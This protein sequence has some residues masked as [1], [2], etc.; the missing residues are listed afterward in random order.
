MGVCDYMAMP[1]A[2]WVEFAHPEGM[3][4]FYH[5][6]LHVVTD[7]FIRDGPT[8]AALMAHYE[9]ITDLLKQREMALADFSDLFMQLDDQNVCSYYIVDHF[10]RSLF[11]LEDV[12]SEDLCLPY[13]VSAAQLSQFKF[14][15]IHRAHPR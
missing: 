9:D 6:D 4:Y 2:P 10:Q 3:P 12:T 11:W 5:P 1:L 13:A 14:Y 15:S 8:L 7:S